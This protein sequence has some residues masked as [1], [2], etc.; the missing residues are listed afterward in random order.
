MTLGGL[1]GRM[2]VRAQHPG[3]IRQTLL[4]AA[5]IYWKTNHAEALSISRLK[6][7]G[8]SHRVA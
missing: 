8:S 2:G 5:I 7:D 3:A 6:F 4:A 1:F